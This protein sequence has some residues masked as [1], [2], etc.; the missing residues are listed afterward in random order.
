[1]GGLCLGGREKMQHWDMQLTF[2]H[3]LCDRGTAGEAQG[4][5]LRVDCK[6]TPLQVAEQPMFTSLYCA[7]YEQQEEQDQSWGLEL[8]QAGLNKVK[9][10]LDYRLGMNESPLASWKM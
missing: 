4:N 1:M 6:Y 3:N 5:Y 10:T 8:G 9:L 2:L 7:G